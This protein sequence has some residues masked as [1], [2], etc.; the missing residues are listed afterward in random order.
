MKKC[1]MVINPNS[2]KRQRKINIKK[3]KKIFYNYGY[4]LTIIFT[5]YKGHACEII[6]SI[7][8]DL[9]VS[10]GGDGT[11]NEIMTGNF[12]RKKKLLISHIPTGTANDIGAM[13]GYTKSL[14]R[15]IE[16]LLKGKV[17]EIDICTINGRPFTYVAALGKFANIS[18][19]TPRS[20]KKKYGYLAYLIEGL[21]E[22]RKY[23]K[24]YDITY[25]INNEKE[26]VKASFILIS[27][28]NRIAGINNFYHNIKLDDNR[29]EVLFC[30]MTDPKEILK[31]LYYLKNGDI[32]KVPGFRFYKTDKMKLKF[33]D[34]IDT[35]F[36][37]DGEKL[38]EN[39]NEYEIAIKRGVKVL[40]PRKNI[41]RLFLNRE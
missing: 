38:D 22:L 1:I 41:S 5:E 8:A 32:S 7:S 39:S 11:Y 14:Y 25:K 2:G 10:V 33:N 23:T 12:E 9:V 4:E 3:V 17:K 34:K 27:N 26:N 30:E 36:S 24:K 37:I 28:A 18:Y 19:D 29:F 40:L 21:K 13:Y 16:L 35:F 20:L 6:K 31:A 15:N